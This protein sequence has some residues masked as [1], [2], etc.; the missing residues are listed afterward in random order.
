MYTPVQNE[1][2]FSQASLDISQANINIS[3][4]IINIS[5]DNHNTSQPNN[6]ASTQSIFQF[7]TL[8]SY[9]LGNYSRKFM[10]ESKYH[11]VWMQY[12][13]GM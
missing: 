8:L 13:V 10:I 4:A 9:V 6:T 3:E 11:M 2:N 12:F 7:A 5:Q 1:V